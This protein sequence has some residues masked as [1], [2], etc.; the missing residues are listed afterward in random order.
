M[1]DALEIANGK[2][3]GLSSKAA[4][5]HEETAVLEMLLGTP[6]TVFIMASIVCV[7]LI[8]GWK[9]LCPVPL[10]TWAAVGVLIGVSR[11]YLN[12]LYRRQT[13]AERM[14]YR[15]F[16]V[17]FAHIAP[18]SFGVVYSVFVLA[19][20]PDLTNNGRLVMLIVGAGLLA[21]S[22]SF[23]A[24]VGMPT[25]LMVLVSNMVA[26]YMTDTE[27]SVPILVICA[28][29]MFLFPKA[30]NN[31]ARLALERMVL[32]EHMQSLSQELGDRNHQLEQ[33][34]DDKSF[35]LASASH[36][37]RQP[38][39]A[40]GL[41]VENLGRA[42]TTN[43]RNQY[44]GMVRSRVELLSD[45]LRSLM[46]VSQLDMGIYSL[47]ILPFNAHDLLKEVAD[48]FAEPARRK[49]LNLELD[50]DGIS[51][52][53]IHSDRGLLGRLISN[54]LSNGI[55]YTQNGRVTVR[56]ESRGNLGLRVVVEDTGPGIDASRHAD[57]FRAYVR[58]DAQGRDPS[59]LG[60][61]LSIVEKGARL[62]GI[63]VDFSSTPGQG[64]S[65]ALL[66]PPTMLSEATV[67]EPPPPFDLE[68]EWGPETEPERR[69]LLVE[70][71][72]VITA[73]M[74]ELLMSW[75]YKVRT[76]ID[77]T[78]AMEVL[79]SDDFT[80]DILLADFQ[81]ADGDNGVECIRRVRQAL[82]MPHLPAILL[83]G[84]VHVSLG[85]LADPRYARLLHKPLR[86]RDL[87][88]TLNDLLQIDS[89]PAWTHSQ[90]PPEI[91][92]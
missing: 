24:L 65:F 20:F 73:A 40:L 57:I 28:I 55:K 75:G 17:R 80:P 12:A 38:V 64:S 35:L 10:Y 43:Q 48:A 68:S 86:P 23:S 70:D 30:R 59:G 7:A 25:V 33:L 45:M 44:L 84:D 56:S 15:Y 27:I 26:W 19:A 32:M 18:A 91:E 88:E 52:T 67:Q 47:Q 13:P 50:I 1:V 36:D 90:P 46:D 4:K 92:Q 60:I 3:T 21:G 41:L 79:N 9:T 77:V 8:V 89:A 87:R 74:T 63:T 85:E 66:I 6:S 71:D 42:S 14:Q 16:W 11:Q 5:R 49:G 62:L 53:V 39:H 37:L 83:T 78:V 61:G 29:G 34:I 31:Q 54:L 22:I 58:I 76:A 2:V 81:L 51:H 72:E 69:A 82:E